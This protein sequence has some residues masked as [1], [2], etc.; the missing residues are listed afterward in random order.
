MN[1]FVERIIST[2]AYGLTVRHYRCPDI[3]KLFSARE[4]GQNNSA[5][6]AD[7]ADSANPADLLW[8]PPPC[9]SREEENLS[10]INLIILNYNNII[11]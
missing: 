3:D 6:C 10:G 8:L 1:E 4:T 9:N 7:S 5:N 2:I 11:L